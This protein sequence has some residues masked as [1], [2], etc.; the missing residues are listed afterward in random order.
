MRY[1]DKV[2]VVTGGSK[3]IGEGCVRVFVEAG[4]KVVFCARGRAGGE[5]LARE[6]N[7]RGPGEAHFVP[8]DVSRVEEIES[9]I[10][11]AVERHGRLDCL[12]NNAGWHPP[13]K[14]ID[15]FSVEEFRSLL[16]LNLVSV[17]AAC[18]FA[19]P[20]LRRTQGNIINLSS[21]VG[22]MGQLHA[23]TYVA[24][25]GAITAFT[26]ALAV[27]E[28]AFDVRVNSVSPGNIYTP[29][30]QEAIDAAPDPAQCRADGEAA[31]L[32]GRMG[33][34]EETGRLCLFLAAEATFTTGV[35]HIQSGGA[36]LGYGRKTRKS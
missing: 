5:R 10:K 17:F 11:K 3:G 27:D 7:A 18:K 21:L 25:K 2:V 28:A 24:T 20:H 6:L 30:W 8:G 35:D 33:T 31:Q 12:I 29:L 36:E 15:G 32:L 23:T 4:A 1:A 26:K 9:L 13:H 19:L 34:I 14:P 22:S 16:D